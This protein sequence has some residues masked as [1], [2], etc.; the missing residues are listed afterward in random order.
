M[1][2]SDLPYVSPDQEVDCS[3]RPVYVEPYRC[4]RSSTPQLAFVRYRRGSRRSLIPWERGD[5]RYQWDGQAWILH[6]WSVRHCL[7]FLLQI[8]SLGVVEGSISYQASC[9]GGGGDV[10]RAQR[11][12]GPQSWRYALPLLPISQNI[13]NGLDQVM[14]LRFCAWFWSRLPVGILRHSL[15]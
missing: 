12:L 7:F 5:L 2:F 9:L 3:A 11:S 10:G 13:L 8:S 4:R 15:A 6:R 14:K 1:C